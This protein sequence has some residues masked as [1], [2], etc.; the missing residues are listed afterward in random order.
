[1]P[2]ERLGDAVDVV[3]KVKGYN[4]RPYTSADVTTI[5]EQALAGAPPRTDG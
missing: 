2:T 4:P 5:L 3:M 1:M